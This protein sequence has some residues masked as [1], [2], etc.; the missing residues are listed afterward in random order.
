MITEDDLRRTL[1]SHERLAPDAAAVAARIT[2]GVRA[3]RRRRYAGTAA[4]AVATAVVVGV[5]TLVLRDAGPVHESGTVAAPAPR[6]VTPAAPPTVLFAPLTV[7][8]TVGWLPRGWFSDG[9]VRTSP[10]FAQRSYENDQGTA[11]MFVQVWDTKVSGKPANDL[12]PIPGGA[13]VRRQLSRTV[14]LLVG[15]PLSDQDLD[16]LVRSVDVRAPEALTFP[17]RVTWLPAG[18]R[19]TAAGTGAHHWYGD[20]AGNTLAADPPLLDAGLSLDRTA[21]GDTLSIWMSTE[22]GMWQDKGLQPNGTLLGRPSRYSERDG[23]TSLHVYGVQGMHISINAATDGRPELD[24]AT[25]ERIVRGLRLV[26]FP[27]R[28]ADWTDRPL[29]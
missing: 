23:I 29:P 19:V 21:T 17:F 14:W 2:A 15:G 12:P 1:H 16:R 22:N 13:V 5:P 27:D 8:F 3:R 26:D 7:P 10:G 24:R 28:P 4:V 9:M 6:S 25:V 20:A 11:E 18:Y